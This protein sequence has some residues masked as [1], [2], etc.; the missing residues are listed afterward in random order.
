MD[1]VNRHSKA[2]IGTFYMTTDLILKV[3]AV[4]YSN[5]DITYSIH[6]RDAAYDVRLWIQNY[7]MHKMVYITWINY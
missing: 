4:D 7:L 1:P 5:E 3:D 6:A 2:D